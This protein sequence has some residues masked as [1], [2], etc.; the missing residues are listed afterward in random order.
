[1]TALDVARRPCSTCPYRRDTPP[2]IWHPDEYR[3][4]PQYDDDQQ[5]TV[6]VFLCH[7]RQ[8][9]RDTACR[10]WLTVA[11]ESA[12]ARL[13]VMTGLVIDEQRYAAVDVDLYATGAEACAAGLAGVDEPDDQACAAIDKLTRR[14]T[15]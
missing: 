3:K 14:A 12:A 13:A 11:R 6:A 1:M 4:L 5:S 9:Q 2:G 7:Q 8:A 10:G 15:R